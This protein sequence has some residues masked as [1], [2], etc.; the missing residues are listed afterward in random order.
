MAQ[1]PNAAKPGTAKPAIQIEEF[2]SFSGIKR[3]TVEEVY[4]HRHKMSP[5]SLR[6]K[7]N[8]FIDELVLPNMEATALMFEEL[9]K[10]ISIHD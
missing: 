9:C 7:V 2:N 4:K 5:K 8:T 10:L 6:K 1:K 3:S